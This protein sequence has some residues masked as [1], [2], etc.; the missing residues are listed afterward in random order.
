MRYQVR[1]DAH[2]Y[3]NSSF[4]NLDQAINLA[5]NLSEEYQTEAFVCHFNKKGHMQIDS[6]YTNG[7]SS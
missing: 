2:S 3:E 6:Y 4:D 5:Y 7:F 1:C